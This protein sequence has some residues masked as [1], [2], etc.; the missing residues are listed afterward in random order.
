[1]PKPAQPLALQEARVVRDL[2][3]H[4][5]IEHGVLARHA[6][7]ELVATPDRHVHEGVKVHHASS[8][9]ALIA[10]VPSGV[11]AHTSHPFAV[12][13]P[14]SSSGAPSKRGARAWVV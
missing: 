4:P 1:M 11:T 7:L 9:C 2:A 12:G 6:A 13:R 10:T 3:E 8:A 5:L 14:R